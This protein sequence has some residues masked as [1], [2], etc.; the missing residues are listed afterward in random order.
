[1]DNV[2]KLSTFGFSSEAFIQDLPIMNSMDRCVQELKNDVIFE[3]VCEQ[4]FLL[5]P[6]SKGE[7]G[8][9]T[10]LKTELKLLT[11]QSK[12]PPLMGK[13]ND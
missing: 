7:S 11:T 13:L 6:F 3:V 10:E 5:K 4:E 2:D 12:L 1:M 9:K 8:A